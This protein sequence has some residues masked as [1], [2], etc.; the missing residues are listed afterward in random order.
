MDAYEGDFAQPWLRIKDAK[1]LKHGKFEHL[2]LLFSLGDPRGANPTFEHSETA[3]LRVVEKN[4]KEGTSVTAHAILCTTPYKTNRYRFIVEDI[5]GLGKTRLRDLL[6]QSFKLISEDLNLEYTNS[7]GEQVATWIIPDIQGYMA[8]TI[9]SSLKRGTLSGV[10]LVD[11][12]AKEKLD[13]V[14]GATISRR[15]LKVDIKDNSKKLITLEKVKNWASEHDF[16]RMR[17]VWNDPQGAGKPERASVDTTQKDV[18][19]NF[20]TKQSKIK[21]SVPIDQA[22]ELLRDDIINKMKNLS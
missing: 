7:S 18:K 8:E 22:C 11:T 20:F 19:D 9:E 15:E 4:E 17:L 5:R 14:S 12:V 6:A 3:K 16:D 10:Y 21:V 2:A 13:E 1:I